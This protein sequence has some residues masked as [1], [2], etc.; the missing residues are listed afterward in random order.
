MFNHDLDLVPFNVLPN[1]KIY[2]KMCLVIVS[3][4]WSLFTH[5]KAFVAP[6]IMH[7]KLFQQ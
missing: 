2:W 3:F 7:E 6:T 1:F 4:V 5:Y